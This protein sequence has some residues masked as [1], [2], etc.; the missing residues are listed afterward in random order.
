MTMALFKT[1][2][3]YR[4]TTI[5]FLT[6]F[7]DQNGNTIQ[8]SSGQVSV[9][10]NTPG[11]QQTTLINMLPPGSPGGDPVQ[12]YAAWDSRGANP[13]TVY[14]SV[15]SGVPTPVVVADGQFQLNANPSNLITF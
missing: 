6:T 1:V 14:W 3:Y 12:W 5:I 7:T 2:I 13:G 8:P 10:F 9:N 11:G 15:H 4:G